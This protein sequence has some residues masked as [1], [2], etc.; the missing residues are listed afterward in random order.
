M[1]NAYGKYFVRESGKYNFKFFNMED[2]FH[3]KVNEASNYLM[4]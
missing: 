2:N 1:V 4:N 3:R